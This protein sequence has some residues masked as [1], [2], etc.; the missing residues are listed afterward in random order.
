MESVDIIVPVFNQVDAT[1]TCLESVRYYSRNYT[2]I[3]IDNGSLKEN[4]NLLEE[5][6]EKHS[7]IKLIRNY[8]NLG[9]VKAINQGLSISSAPYVVL[10]NNDTEVTKN[11]LE[12]LYQPFLENHQIAAVGPITNAEGCWQGTHPVKDSWMMCS[13][14][15][16]LAFFCVML[17]KEAVDKV[18]LLDESFGVGFADDDDYCRRLHLANYRIALAENCFIYHAHRSTFNLLY[19]N[20]EIDKMIESNLS[21]FRDKHGIDKK[22]NKI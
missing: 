5:E 15:T 1:L 12:K 9:F 17:K 22:G 10:L 6:L 4:F 21:I 11:W 7:Q 8:R 16:M 19:S 20:S 3:L 2:L 18:G 13:K 14:T